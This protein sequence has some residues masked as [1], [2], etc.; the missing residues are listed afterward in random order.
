M[1]VATVERDVAHVAYF[2]KCFKG[3]LQAFAQN[4]SSVFICMLWQVF[5]LDVA[6]I[7]HTC[8]KCFIWMLHMFHT[9]VASV[10]SGCC[11]CFMHMLQQ[12]VSNV[13][14]LLDVCCIHVFYE[15]TVSDGRTAGAL[16]DRARRVGG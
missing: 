12:Y 9:H 11:I 1:D 2:C 6:Y 14:S 8:C 13:S 3:M 10:L 5:Y 7:L 15:G 16:G 4:V